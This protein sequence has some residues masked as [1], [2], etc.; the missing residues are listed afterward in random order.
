MKPILGNYLPADIQAIKKTSLDVFQK[1]MP[2]PVTDQDFFL[3]VRFVLDGFESLY[4]QLSD[5][6]LDIVLADFSFVSMLIK[7]FHAMLVLESCR[8]KNLSLIISSYSNPLYEPDWN[9][10]GRMFH[11]AIHPRH[12]RHLRRLAMNFVFNGSS[13]SLFDQVK[14]FFSPDG[15][16]L[17]SKSTL[18]TEYLR[19]KKLYIDYHYWDTFFGKFDLTTQNDLT[20]GLKTKLKEFVG[21]I[22]DFLS[23]RFAIDL[24]VTPIIRC[25]F[26]RLTLLNSVYAAVIEKKTLTKLFLFTET[27]QPLNR[28]VAHAYKHKGLNVV[29]FSH[30]NDSG[31]STDQVMSYL[32]PSSCTEYVLPT[33][34]SARS[35][36]KIYQKTKISEIHKTE[37]VSTKTDFYQRLWKKN[38]LIPFPSRIQKVMILGYPMNA[39]RYYFNKALFWHFQLDLEIRLISLLQKYGFQVLYKIHPDRVSEAQYIFESLNVQII[40]EPFENVWQQADALLIKNTASSTFGFALCVNRPIFLLDLNEADWQSDHYQLIKK[41]CEMIPA[42]VDESNQIQFEHNQLIQSLSRKPSNPDYSYIEKYMFPE[43]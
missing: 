8:N 1:G 6:E 27:G 25:W 12:S 24:S 4:L 19:Q 40:A 31:G 7:H 29:S 20:G 39:N 14:G 26:E 23:Q 30:G 32:G 17:C 2:W 34:A 5:D 15:L 18:R 38:Q 13:L 36:Q 28:V 16:G 10:L 9:S 41:R 33:K 3:M 21:S 35:L 37:F 42:W 22:A 43:T 11:Q